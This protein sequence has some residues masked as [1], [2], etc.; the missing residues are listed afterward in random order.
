MGRPNRRETRPR[1]V[2]LDGSIR[3]Q[4]S[5]PPGSIWGGVDLDG[6]RPGFLHIVRVCVTHAD[7]DLRAERAH[8]MPKSTR[9]PAQEYQF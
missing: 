8:G 2:N 6:T 5:S 1:D 7:W 3:H 4:D 9:H